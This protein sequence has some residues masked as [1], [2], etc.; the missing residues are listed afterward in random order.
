MSFVT[1]FGIVAAFI[2]AGLAYWLFTLYER[3]EK[4]VYDDVIF[5][6]YMPQYSNGH[7]FGTINKF[8]YGTNRIGVEFAPKDFDKVKFQKQKKKPVVPAE[9]VYFDKGKFHWF[10][11]G[12]L[13]AERNLCF[14]LPPRPE[15]LPEEIKK[16]SQG[17][18]LMNMIEGS[19]ADQEEISILRQRQKRQTAMLEKSEGLEIAQDTIELSKEA[20]ELL[21]KLFTKEDKI[22]TYYSPEMR[23]GIGG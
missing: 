2:I 22:R 11:K 18:F 17:R 16:T 15:I 23:Q 6:N 1:F 21:K 3:K 8:T 5:I 4:E 19:N 14:G 9:K 20:N 13:S 12:T 10:P 7:A